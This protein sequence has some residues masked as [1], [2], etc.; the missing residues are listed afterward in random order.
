MGA[1][2]IQDT[3]FPV[4]ASAV[5][6]LCR[7]PEHFVTRREIVRLILQE[8]LTR[9]LIETAYKKTQRKSSI[10]KYAG[11]MVDWFSQ[12]W[13]VGDRKWFSL[14]RKFE[15]SEKKIDGCHAY[16]PLA[17]AGIVVFPDEVEEYLEKL[18]EGAVYERL[19]N[20]YERNPLARQL[21]VK[22]Y[23]TNCHVCGFSFGATYGELVNGFIHVHHLVQLSEVGE[24]YQVDPI[25][26]LRPVCPN[27]HAVIHHRRNAPYSIEQVRSFL[28]R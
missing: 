15:R 10:E 21:C 18:P 14:F 7:G 1:K 12:R 20:G 27:C 9:K 6:R 3:A 28:R 8:T 2:W 25:A 17:P 22:K 4:I 11:N 24:E 5:E 26:D 19:V 13:T 16:K 23:G